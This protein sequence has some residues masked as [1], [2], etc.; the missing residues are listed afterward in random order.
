MREEQWSDKRKINST[1]S[2]LGVY[3]FLFY[4]LPLAI[5]KYLENFKHIIDF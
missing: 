3:T 5:K 4:I 1:N 2:K